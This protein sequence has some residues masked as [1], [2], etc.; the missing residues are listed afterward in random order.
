MNIFHVTNELSTKNYSISSIILFLT[1]N[2]FKKNYNK[3]P[4]IIQKLDNYFKN[5]NEKL[6]IINSLNKLYKFFRQ[7]NHKKNIFHI[8][9]I[10]SLIQIS[11][12]VICS[13]RKIKVFIH[14]HGM[15]LPEA[16][17]SE[18]SVKNILKIIIL[19]IFKVILRENTN[20]ITVTNYE[21][22]QVKKFFP[23]LQITKINNP[24]PFNVKKKILKKR[25]LKKKIVYFGRIH[26]HKNIELMINSFL[27]AK[28][29]KSWSLEIFGLVDNQRYLNKIKSLIKRNKNVFLKKPIFDNKKNYVMQTAWL[30][31]LFSK[32]EVLSLSILEASANGLPTLITN[33]L[34]F[35]IN[36][37]SIIKSNPKVDIL[38]NSIKKISLLKQHQRIFLGK[39]IFKKFNVLNYNNL[40]LEKYVNIINKANS[41][42]IKL[43]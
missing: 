38:S 13:L 3:H 12:I 23:K 35:E 29:D 11:F 4:I 16:L 40:I 7:T 2:I 6:L 15:L 39:K 14:P 22:K 31:L 18:S 27:N 32:S 8:H 10:W 1:N 20:F 25:K 41:K 36:K 34:N 30:N 5:K 19:K 33:N 17:N 28:L 43:N 42:K 24:I 21:T 37:N 26:P 9:G